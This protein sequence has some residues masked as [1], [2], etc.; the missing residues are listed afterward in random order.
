MIKRIARTAGFSGLLAALLLTFLQSLWVS[1]LILEAETYESAAP[2]AEHHDHGDAVAAHEHDAE[3]WAPEDGWQRLLSTT[4][5]N[6]VV[7]VGFALILAA[8]YSLREP[9]RVATGALWG[10]AGFAV[11]CLAPTLGLPPELPGTA[12]ADLGQR[13]GWWIGTAAAT[14]AGLALLV[15]AHHWLFK[16]LGLALLVV[17]H[18]IGAPQPA[19]HESLAPEALETQFKIAS[20]VTNAAFWLALGLLSAWLYRRTSQ[21]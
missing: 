14:A 20:W 5:G 10:L 4:G 2:V 8:L 15:F 12:A 6:L 7:A 21:A 3:A 18:L 19:T 17:P 11:F 9:G 16:V 13:Q 1:P